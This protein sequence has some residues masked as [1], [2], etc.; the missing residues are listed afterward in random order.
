VPAV[1]RARFAILNGITEEEPGRKRLWGNACMPLGFT[2]CAEDQAVME[3][4]MLNP[5]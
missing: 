1:E 3:D 4:F 5:F 2:R